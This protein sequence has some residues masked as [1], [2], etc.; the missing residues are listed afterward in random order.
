[1][2]SSHAAN[3]KEMMERET[4]EMAIIGSRMS[5][6]KRRGAVKT[7]KLADHRPGTQ[8]LQM[9]FYCQLLQGIQTWP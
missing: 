6:H 3:V 9:L 2:L 1:M 4:I 5:R 7:P 8:P